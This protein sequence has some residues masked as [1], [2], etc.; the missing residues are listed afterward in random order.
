ML[1][2]LDMTTAKKVVLFSQGG[3][4]ESHDTLLQSLIN[5]RIGLF[6]AVGKD[7]EIWEDVMDELVVGPK[8]DYEW[9]VNTTSHPNETLAE[10]IEFAEMFDLNEPTS[11]EVIEV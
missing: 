7:C 5:R 9:H 6:C 10:V 2:L 11:V 3:Y 1:E 4:H 8:R